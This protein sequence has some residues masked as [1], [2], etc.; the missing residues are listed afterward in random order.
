MSDMPSAER[1]RHQAFKALGKGTW[2]GR[3]LSL[4]DPCLVKQ[5]ERQVVNR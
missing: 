2:I 1:P 3:W 4:C 5:Q